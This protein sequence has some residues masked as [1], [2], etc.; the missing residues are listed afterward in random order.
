MDD[1]YQ[2]QVIERRR[3]ELIAAIRVL[4]AQQVLLAI[5]SEEL[6]DIESFLEAVSQ[7]DDFNA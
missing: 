5:Y 1:T 3:Q 7:E 4:E 6:S 2:L